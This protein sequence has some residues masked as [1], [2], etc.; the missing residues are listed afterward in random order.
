MIEKL[1]D[2]YLIATTLE[3]DLSDLPELPLKG[4]KE[5]SLNSHKTLWE[6]YINNYNKILS[7]INKTKPIGTNSSYSEYGELQRRLIYCHNG[8]LLHKLYFQNLGGE[9]GESKEPEYRT[10]RLINKFHKSLGKFKKSIIASALVPPSGWV[11]WGWSALDQRT[12][13]FVLEEHANNCPIGIVPLLVIDIW[14]HAYHDFSIDREKYLNK[15]WKDIDWNVVEN[16]IEI[17]ERY[18]K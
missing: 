7:L 4:I 9:S 6:G 14:E 5:K 11:V 15:I 1:A 3:P 12:H 16:R 8:A 18:L 17:M 2:L 13:I 10:L